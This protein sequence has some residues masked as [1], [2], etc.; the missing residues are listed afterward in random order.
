MNYM[1]R[2][3]A[4]TSTSPQLPISKTV[5]EIIIDTSTGIAYKN[6]GSIW[7]N[8]TT[9]TIVCNAAKAKIKLTTPKICDCCGAKIYGNKCDYCG[10]E[11]NYKEV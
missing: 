8:I 10:V 7:S 2:T 3:W 9:D 6:D 4:L 1:H 11:Y 5:G